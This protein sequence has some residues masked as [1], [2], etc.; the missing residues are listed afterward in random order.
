MLM[1]GLRGQAVRQ[2]R[3]PVPAGYLDGPWLWHNGAC[4]KALGLCLIAAR[5][6]SCP[7][8]PRPQGSP[9]PPLA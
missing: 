1:A 2:T 3:W 4:A 7:D 8:D 5:S 9:L 6:G